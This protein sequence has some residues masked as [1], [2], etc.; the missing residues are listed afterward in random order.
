M[1]LSCALCTACS[2]TPTY[3]D[4][5]IEL[6]I[7]EHKDNKPVSQYTLDLIQPRKALK[8][9]L[10]NYNNKLTETG[11]I[12]SESLEDDSLVYFMISYLNESTQ[13]VVTFNTAENDSLNKWLLPNQIC[14]NR[15]FSFVRINFD[16][17]PLSPLTT[18]PIFRVKFTKK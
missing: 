5:R 6:E 7:L 1:L 17:A 18:E 16:Q 13:Q 4:F 9:R 10:A 14:T 11:V 8:T 2:V 15:N 3:T 12:F